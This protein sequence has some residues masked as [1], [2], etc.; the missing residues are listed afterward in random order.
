MVGGFGR[1]YWFALFVV[2]VCNHC[3]EGEPTWHRQ[4]RLRR[5]RARSLLRHHLPPPGTSAKRIQKAV[6]L[7][8]WHHGSRPPLRF[9]MESCGMALPLQAVGSSQWSKQK[10]LQQLWGTLHGS[11][12]VAPNSIPWSF[13][14][15][16]TAG[17]TASEE[18]QGTEGLPQSATFR[19][20]R[21]SECDCS[22]LGDEY[23][24]QNGL[25]ATSQRPG[26]WGDGPVFGGQ[27]REGREDFGERPGG[28]IEAD[29]HGEGY[30][31]C[32]GF[33]QAGCDREDQSR[34]GSSSYHPQN[35]EST[36]E[37][38]EDLREHQDADRRV[39]R[40]VESVQRS[41]EDQ[42]PRAGCTLQGQEETQ[43]VT[44]NV[45]TKE[46]ITQLRSEIQKAAVKTEVQEIPEEFLAEPDLSGMAID[47]TMTDSDDDR[48]R[49]RSRKRQSPLKTPNGEAGRETRTTN[50]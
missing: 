12:V 4:L 2:G 6:Q 19:N 17:K 33:S 11:E 50:P 5:K 49:S 20:R 44:K 32:R 31:G 35:G 45:E 36:P 46:K 1:N 48:P 7:L 3:C 21:F 37:S 16:E 18:Y 30:F 23:S 41:P 39:G 24:Y 34:A 14:Q 13:C 43:L 26:T 15:Q 25:F 47:L 8:F 27:E 28:G 40:E 10:L 29:P 22:S 9:T 42:V 38:R